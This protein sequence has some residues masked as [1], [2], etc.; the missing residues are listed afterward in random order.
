MPIQRPRVFV[1]STIRDFADLRDA[2]RFWLEEMGF[3]VQLSEHT[4]FERRPEANAFDA[5]FESIRTADFYILLIGDQRGSWYDESSRVSVTREEYRC[6]RESFER[7]GA[8]R[9]VAAVRAHVLTILRERLSLG[10]PAGPSTLQDWHFT[11]D[12]VREVRREDEV[13]A[14]VKQGG[15]YPSSNWV[16]SFRDFRELTGI[17]RSTLAIRGPLPRAAASETVRQECQKNLLVLLTNHRGSPFYQYWWLDRVRKEVILTPED[18]EGMGQNV[19]LTHEQIKQTVG[20]LVGSIPSPDQ[21][22]RSSLDQV[23]ASGLLLDYDR[24]QNRFLPSSI[25]TAICLLRS[26]LDLFSRRHGLLQRHQEIISVAW[27]QSRVNGSSV[28]VPAFSLFALY[29]VQDNIQNIARLLIGILRHLYGHTETVEVQLLPPSP[30]PEFY[31]EIR[32]ENVSEDRLEEWLQSDNF[33]LSLGMREVTEEQ[34][35]QRDANE[36]RL[37]ELLGDAGFEQ[38]MREATELVRDYLAEDNPRDS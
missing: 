13:E 20:F 29:A 4:D 34:R 23:V 6:A 37:R 17:L 8:P 35:Q 24:S 36:A 11:A 1:S 28:E 30:I 2:L 9:I 21:F 22:V 38:W 27:E 14:A 7:T 25:L 10:M 32:R 16:S 33:L 19:T 12:F 18:L 31:A 5:C 3:E 26:E 15:N